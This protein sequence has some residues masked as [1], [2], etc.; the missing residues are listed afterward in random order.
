[1]NIYEYIEIT[2]LVTLSHTLQMSEYTH[3][4]NN[5]ITGEQLNE[6]RLKFVV[7]L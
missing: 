4:Y 5:R 1:M 7:S 6:S 2:G 3:G